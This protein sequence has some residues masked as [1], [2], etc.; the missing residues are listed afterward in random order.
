MRIC[1]CVCKHA[2]T[3]LVF[4]QEVAGEA[5]ELGQRPVSQFLRGKCQGEETP[6]LGTCG[7]WVQNI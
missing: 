2:C 1:A 7:C 4:F 3:R 6:R 5:Q